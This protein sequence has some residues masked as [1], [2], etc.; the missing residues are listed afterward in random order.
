MLA[1]TNQKSMST[2]KAR[3]KQNMRFKIPYLNCEFCDFW[4]KKAV[5]LGK[6]SAL[7]MKTYI[8]CGMFK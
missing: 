7:F 6:S 8:S 3:L 2:V 4:Y 5:G 1:K